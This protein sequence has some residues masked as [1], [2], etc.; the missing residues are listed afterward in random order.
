M[1]RKPRHIVIAVPAYDGKLCVGTSRSILHDVMAMVNGG[2]IMQVAEEVGNADISNCRAMIVA[3]FLAIEGAT[4]LVMVDSDVAWEG[5]GLAKLINAGEDFVAGLYPQRLGEGNRYHCQL[6]KSDSHSCNHKGLLEVAAVPAG[7]MCLTRG[8]LVR[9]TTHYDHMRFSFKSHT[10][11]GYAWDLFD[12]YW[13]Q[14]ADGMKHKMGEDY[15]FCHRWR[16]MGGKIWVDPSI[17]MG[18]IGTK[19]WSGR[20]ADGFKAPEA[21]AA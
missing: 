19:M 11:H 12:G 8:M 4:H 6:L 5:G 7:F 2:D 10:P 13:T 9:M 20:F 18:H 21:A 1:K 15:A 16:D 17:H 14:D 3:K